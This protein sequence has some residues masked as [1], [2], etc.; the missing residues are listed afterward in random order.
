MKVD[1]DLL[2]NVVGDIVRLVAGD[3]ICMWFSVCQN[4]DVMFMLLLAPLAIIACLH[5][6][7]P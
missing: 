3:H 4:N 6:T 2:E 7:C 1:S 5:S